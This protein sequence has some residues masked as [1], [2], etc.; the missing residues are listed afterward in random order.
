[1]GNLSRIGKKGPGVQPIP[2]QKVI[3]TPM[4]LGSRVDSVDGFT[5]HNGE[6]FRLRIRGK[7]KFKLQIQY[8]QKQGKVNMGVSISPKT[9]F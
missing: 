4:M 9:L 5:I 2:G 1:M 8:D 7:T 6:E 3:I